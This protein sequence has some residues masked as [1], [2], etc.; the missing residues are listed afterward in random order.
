MYAVQ[1]GS[2]IYHL[3]DRDLNETLCGQRV[4]EWQL[5][6]KKLLEQIRTNSSEVAVCKHCTRLG[7]ADTLI[8]P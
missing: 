8:N 6:S 7:V 1:K 2:S 4:T 3:L 5:R